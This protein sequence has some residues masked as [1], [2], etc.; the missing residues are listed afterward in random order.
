M[1]LIA[2]D[3]APAS[4]RPPLVGLLI[5]RTIVPPEDTQPAR[6]LLSTS[7]CWVIFFSS[8]SLLKVGPVFTQLCRD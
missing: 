3:S 7:A 2:N 4:G 6:L 5:Y 8:I 1:N